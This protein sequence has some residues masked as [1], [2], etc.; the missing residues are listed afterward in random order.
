MPTIPSL[1]PASVPS[2]G[3][4]AFLKFVIDK[5]RPGEPKSQDLIHLLYVR[6]EDV[7][8][9]EVFKNNIVIK[10]SVG[11]SSQTF[12][13]E[14]DINRPSALVPTAIK[15]LLETLGIL[16]VVD[17]PTQVDGPT[18][19]VPVNLRIRGVNQVAKS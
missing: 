6:Y 3:S 7:E 17:V 9:V 2:A 11:G 14:E 8:A 10:L 16:R 15:H 13:I 12:T 18:P 4:S 19:G 1:T 5:N